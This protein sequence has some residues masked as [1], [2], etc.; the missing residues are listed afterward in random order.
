MVAMTGLLAPPLLLLLL[1]L[2][3]LLSVGQATVAVGTAASSCSVFC[4][5]PILQA[6]QLSGLFNDSKTFVDRPL[7]ADPAEVLADFN[8]TFPNPDNITHAALA[9]FVDQHFGDV[10]SDVV[11]CTPGDFQPKPDV[12]ERKIVANAS[13]QFAL[14]VNSIWPQLC[15]TATEDV[16]THPSRHTLLPSPHPLIVPGGRFRESYYWDTCVVR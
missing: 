12:I 3:S 2:L 10:G 4:Q 7:L 15:R 8:A 11:N 13:R 6:V 14:A 16:E 1:L 9:A 5:G